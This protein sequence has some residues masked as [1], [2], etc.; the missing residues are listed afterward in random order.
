[1]AEFRLKAKKFISKRLLEFMLQIIWNKTFQEERMLRMLD[2][3]FL[4]YRKVRPP[5]CSNKLAAYGF[6]CLEKLTCYV[7]MLISYT[8]LN[9]TALVNFWQPQ[10]LE[11]V[12]KTERLQTRKSM[13]RRKRCSTTKG[14][15]SIIYSGNVEWTTWK[16]LK[17]ILSRLIK[18]LSSK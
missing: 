4:A 6:R 2:Q 9:N 12:D 11:H 16:C 3:S 8:H 1:M 10:I 14:C 17:I 5:C 18:L 13:W 7:H 15:H